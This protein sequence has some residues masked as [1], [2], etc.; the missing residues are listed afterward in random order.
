[1]TRLRVLVSVSP[2]RAVIVFP[3]SERAFLGSSGE[4][5]SNRRVF[6]DTFPSNS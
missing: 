2:S 3:T 4:R 5:A 1:M 6:S